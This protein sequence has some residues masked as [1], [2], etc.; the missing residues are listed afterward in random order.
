MISISQKILGIEKRK[1]ISRIFM[2]W[3][4]FF[5]KTRSSKIL[6]N[7]WKLQLFPRNRTKIFKKRFFVIFRHRAAQ[8][9]SFARLYRVFKFD[10]RNFLPTCPIDLS[11]ST[12]DKKNLRKKFSFFFQVLRS[13]RR[14]KRKLFFLEK[15]FF[16]KSFKS[17]Q[18][19]CFTSQ[20]SSIR[21]FFSKIQYRFE[22]QIFKKLCQKSTRSTHNRPSRKA[23][24][25]VSSL[26]AQE[27]SNFLTFCFKKKTI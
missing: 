17:H 23:R 4:K 14:K 8:S 6:Q 27:I 10:C 7:N 9:T 21:F 13:I 1:K 2:K 15:I 25:Q 11:D 26:S 22:F 24:G 5:L 16:M 18:I 20:T 3:L 12:L 19:K